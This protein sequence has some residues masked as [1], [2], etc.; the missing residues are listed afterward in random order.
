MSK[1]KAPPVLRQT[2]AYAVNQLVIFFEEGFEY[3]ELE[4]K[5]AGMTEQAHRMREYRESIQDGVSMMTDF[6]NEGETS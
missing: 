4:F 3:A 5:D 1:P 6:A 2:V